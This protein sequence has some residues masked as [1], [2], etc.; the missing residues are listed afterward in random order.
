MYKIYKKSKPNDVD[1]S[2]A[3]SWCTD[4]YNRNAEFTSCDW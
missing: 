4:L 1:V 2:I 3:R